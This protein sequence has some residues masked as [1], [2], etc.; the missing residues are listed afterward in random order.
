VKAAAEHGIPD[1][2]GILFPDT[3]NSIPEYPG[4]SFPSTW[5][6]DIP[7]FILKGGCSLQHADMAGVPLEH[8]QQAITRA[9]VN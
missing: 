1:R 6:Q 3:G 9:D 2:S 4:I 5:E 8:G 7:Q